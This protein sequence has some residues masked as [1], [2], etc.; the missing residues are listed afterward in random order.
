MGK[1]KIFTH[2]YPVFITL[3]FKYKTNTTSLAIVK[4]ILIKT[5]T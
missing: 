4:D 3:L 2:F 1:N 5:F